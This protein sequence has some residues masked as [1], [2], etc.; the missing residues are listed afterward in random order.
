MADIESTNTRQEFRI[1]QYISY[2][3]PFIIFLGMVR[4]ITFYNAFGVSIISYLD[5]SEI[6]T[7][8]FDIL[9]FVIIYFAYISIQ[10]FVA[11]DKEQAN[12][13]NKKRQEIINENDFWKIIRLYITYFKKLLI[14]EFLVILGCLFSHFVYSWI[15][16]WTIFIVITTFFFLQVFLIIIVEIERKH[17]HLESSINRKRFISMTLYF[18]VFTMGVR[19]Y[20][21]YQAGLIKREKST[22]GVTIS[23][24]NEQTLVSDSTSYFIGKTLNY[25][26]I[27][28]EK[29]NTTDI[30]PM[31]RIKQ[32]TMVHKKND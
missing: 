19:Y 23:L 20:S 9:I 7:S 15:S 27:Y 8:F 18:L 32:I 22:Y 16:A 17:I 13:A 5:F 2:V 10:N 29:Q 6:I 28:D 1:S 12:E 4:L 3:G 21:S 31:T 24:D 25:V 30:I 26:F 11:G 14:F